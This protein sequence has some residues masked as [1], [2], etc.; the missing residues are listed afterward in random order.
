M[1]ANLHLPGPAGQRAAVHPDAAVYELLSTIPW[2]ARPSGTSKATGGLGCFPT[3]SRPTLFLA[4]SAS[5]VST[6]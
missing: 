1:P 3:G 6:S 5:V 4:L 2:G